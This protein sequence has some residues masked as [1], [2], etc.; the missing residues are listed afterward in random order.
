[1]TVFLDVG[2]IYKQTIK[3]KILHG[4]A[5]SRGDP[6]KNIYLLPRQGIPF[7]RTIILIATFSTS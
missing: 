5:G 6:C 7:L 1:M 3:I 4:R 2:I